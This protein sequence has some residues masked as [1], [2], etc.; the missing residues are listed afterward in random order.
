[1][2]V[3][4]QIFLLN[5]GETHCF[6]PVCEDASGDTVAQKNM[7]VDVDVKERASGAKARTWGTNPG[8]K[9][10]ERGQISH[11]ALKTSASKG[12]K[13]KPRGSKTKIK[14]EKRGTGPAQGYPH[15][16]QTRQAGAKLT[17]RPTQPVSTPNDLRN[18]GQ[19]LVHIQRSVSDGP[20]EDK[21]HN[22]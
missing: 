3:Y 15:R 20:K 21:M 17:R 7:S 8:I 18:E 13:S 14:L 2:C 16:S 9:S 22:T 5:Y 6:P 1:M 19:K 4:I 11:R 12:P 10:V